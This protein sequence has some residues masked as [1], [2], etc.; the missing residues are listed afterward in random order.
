MT[1]AEPRP[2]LLTAAMV[3]G[4]AAGGF[5]DGILFHQVLQ[6][7]HL[8]SLVPGDRFRDPAVQI[9]ADGAFHILMYVVAAVGLWLLWRARADFDRAAAA[10]R[11]GGGLLI[12]F[13]LW[14]VVD[15]VVFHWVLGI[16]HIRLGVENPVAYD[17]AVL[18]IGV[19]SGALGWLVLRK[20]PGGPSRRPALAPALVGVSVALAGA[21]AAR[22]VG[23]G[24]AATVLFAEAD[25]GVSALAAA[26]QSGAALVSISAD[27]RLASYALQGADAR[28]LR[29]AGAVWVSRNAGPAGCFSRV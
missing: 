18:L 16:H 3:L 26:A 11:L 17:V 28:D 1:R 6:W 7:H 8:L 5:I 13:G 12:G 29:R 22:P 23:A 2:P 20:G 10:R 9:A 24:D 19:A 15:A 14:Q 25:G 27:G 21:Q 4:L